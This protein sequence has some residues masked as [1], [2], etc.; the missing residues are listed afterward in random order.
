MPKEDGE[1]REE[2]ISGTTELSDALSLYHARRLT[3]AGSLYSKLFR[4]VNFVLFFPGFSVDWALPLA[5]VARPHASPT[6]GALHCMTTMF[7]RMRDGR[8]ACVARQVSQ[9]LEF[10][11][12]LPFN[13]PFHSHYSTN[14]EQIRSRCLLGINPREVPCKST[15]CS[16]I[17]PISSLQIRHNEY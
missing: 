2:A 3:T 15:V 14:A 17:N 5:T 1:K 8:M 12:V 13:W 16:L 4:T 9:S 6:H 10:L 7:A 11:F